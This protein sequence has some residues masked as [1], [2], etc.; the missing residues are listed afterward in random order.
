MK[1]YEDQVAQRGWTKQ[2]IADAINNPY[3]VADS[4]NKFTGN[5]AKVYY[6]DEVHYVVIDTVTRKVVQISD[7]L[8][9]NWEFTPENFIK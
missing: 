7:L 3:K 1:D 8:K 9:D 5:P 4:V 2:Q 6:I